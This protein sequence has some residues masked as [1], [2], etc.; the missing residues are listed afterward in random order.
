MFA[1]KDPV[2]VD[3]VALNFMGFTVDKVSHVMLAGEKNLGIS[4]LSQI[5]VEG[6]VLDEI[7][8]TFKR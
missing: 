1:G 6:A 2:A 3:T 7:K 8:M 4:D 5:T